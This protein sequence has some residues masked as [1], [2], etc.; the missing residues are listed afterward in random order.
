MSGWP[1]WVAP[2]AGAASVV[3]VAVGRIPVINHRLAHL[4]EPLVRWWT[5]GELVDAVQ[6]HEIEILARRTQDMDILQAYVIYVTRWMVNAQVTAARQG[7][8]LDPPQGFD[9]FKAQWLHRHPDYDP[10]DGDP[11]L[12][13]SP[14]PPPS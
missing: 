8:V 9:E 10:T 2:V 3:L 11:D 1:D 7:L 4:L 5:R 14:S 12:E 13:S 6:R